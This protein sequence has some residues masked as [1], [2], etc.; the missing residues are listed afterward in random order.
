MSVLLEA[1]TCHIFESKKKKKK[2]AEASLDQ[3]TAAARSSFVTFSV[4]TAPIPIR[5]KPDF[6]MADPTRLLEQCTQVFFCT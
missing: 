2:A 1:I 4:A 5:A 3:E 6:R